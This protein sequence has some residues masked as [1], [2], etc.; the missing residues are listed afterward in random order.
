MEWIFW[1]MLLAAIAHV[2]E[3]YFGGFIGQVGRIVPGVTFV[4]FAVINALFL[5][6]CLA[7]ALA[8]PAYLIFSMAVPALLIINALIHMGAAV[9]LRGYAAGLITALVL[10]LPLSAYAYYH[11][12]ADGT[13]RLQ[14]AILSAALGAILMLVP[15]LYRGVRLARDGKLSR[16]YIKL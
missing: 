6:I 3:E 14:G 16:K 5:V 12:M 2:A 9:R 11:F 15:L 8:P 10:Y 13:L 4:Q 7:G 1:A